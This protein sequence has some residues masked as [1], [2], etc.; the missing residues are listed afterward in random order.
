MSNVDDPSWPDN[1]GQLDSWNTQLDQLKLDIKHL[2]T[3]THGGKHNSTFLVMRFI[4][5][6]LIP[7]LTNF[8]QGYKMKRESQTANLLNA[9]QIERN[10]INKAYNQ[11]QQI[12]NPQD[13]TPSHPTWGGLG[14][15]LQTKVEDDMRTI[16]AATV[17]IT[18][19][20]NIGS[21]AIAPKAG[22]ELKKYGDFTDK[23][24]SNPLFKTGDET[25]MGG[26]KDQMNVLW[27]SDGSMTTE[28][29][30]EALWNS[31]NLLPTGTTPSKTNP[32]PRT[33]A[34]A[35]T[36]P[37]TDA[38][39]GMASATTGLNAQVMAEEKFLD[40]NSQKWASI[41]KDLLSISIK[42]SKASIQ[43][44]AGTG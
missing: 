14:S 30:A 44:T 35:T 11:I 28:G 25:F 27:N 8:N 9:I 3:S 38:L 39:N 43:Q 15:T 37:Y 4:N 20:F 7:F 17:E 41:E 31:W 40:S 33:D 1:P 24:H 12:T 32:N 22:A 16:Q 29:Q 23:Q 10:K 2:E 5:T 6:T 36:T 26:Y 13:P 21:G 34:G 18:R 19:L 42:S